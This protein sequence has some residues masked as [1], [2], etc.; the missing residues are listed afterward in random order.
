M[1]L[2]KMLSV[3]NILISVWVSSG[4]QVIF[5]GIEKFNGKQNNTVK[6]PILMELIFSWGLEAAVIFEEK[7]AEKEADEGCRA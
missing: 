3:F 2:P 4:R 7:N 6:T 5:L 1:I